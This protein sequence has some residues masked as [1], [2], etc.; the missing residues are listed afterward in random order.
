[1]TEGRGSETSEKEED[2]EEDDEKEEED[3]GR[4]GMTAGESTSFV[5]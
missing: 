1:M 2:E 5:S 3:E 4:G